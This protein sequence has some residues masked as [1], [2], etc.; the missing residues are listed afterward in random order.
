MRGGMR[1]EV[2][3]WWNIQGERE[4]ENLFVVCRCVLVI[5]HYHFANGK[6]GNA[7]LISHWER[8][9]FASV[10]T[11]S[12]R[13]LLSFVFFFLAAAAAAW[14]FNQLGAVRVWQQWVAFYFTTFHG[15]NLNPWSP[16]II[17]KTTVALRWWWW[18]YGRCQRR[19]RQ[20]SPR[21]MFV[22]KQKRKG[23]WNINLC[24][25]YIL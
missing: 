9:E 14:N 15:F 18:W 4:R 8:I 23:V 7:I 6:L 16:A 21:P 5:R 11:R 25:H 3:G 24:S 10:I 19:R 1:N 22:E 2:H 17:Y 13:V 20:Q 12:S